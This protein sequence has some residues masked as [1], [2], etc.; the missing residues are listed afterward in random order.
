MSTQRTSTSKS[1]HANKS[2]LTTTTEKQETYPRLQDGDVEHM[3]PFT[4]NGKT[5]DK[6]MVA[7]RLDEWSYLVATEDASYKQSRVDLRKTKEMSQP[8]TSSIK[9]HEID[10]GNGSQKPQP[11]CQP[12]SMSPSN[13]QKSCCTQVTTAPPCSKKPELGCPNKPVSPTSV[14]VPT[15]TRPRRAVREPAYLKDY[16][17]NWTV[18]SRF[19]NI[20]SRRQI[21]RTRTRLGTTSF[22][23]LPGVMKTGLANI[24][25]FFQLPL[26]SSLTYVYCVVCLCVFFLVL[27]LGICVEV[28][29][30]RITILPRSQFF[31]LPT[32]LSL[33]QVTVI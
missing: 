28:E 4:L 17:R 14:S 11:L 22:I 8:D 19:T 9:R 26:S 33:T 5:W 10:S 29:V 31:S 16:I 6:V 23:H 13:N 1:K 30:D 7:K 32:I 2:K 3:R 21:P 20:E 12:A 24:L 27:W 18:N 25:S 15:E